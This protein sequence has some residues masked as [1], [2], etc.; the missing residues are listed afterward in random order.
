M[1]EV[2]ERMGTDRLAAT[3]SAAFQAAFGE[4]SPT[5]LGLLPPEQQAAWR[6]VAA[7]GDEELAEAE[8]RA[9]PEIGLRL[10]EVYD[11]A[12]PPIPP[13]EALKLRLAWEATARH[14]WMVLDEEQV[15]DL[16]ENEHSWR[17]WA[18]QRLGQLEN[19]SA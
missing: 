14:L 5:P 2:G 6:R 8:G 1:A 13:G 9:F 19:A 3:L 11:P 17:E 18:R 4:L 7:R 15:D 12:L 10:R 16:R